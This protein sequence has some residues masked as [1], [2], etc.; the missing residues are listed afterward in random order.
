MLRFLLAPFIAFAHLYC[1][2]PSLA[3]VVDQV[4]ASVVHI[5]TFVQMDDQVGVAFCT[6]EVVEHDRVL[7]A[8]HCAGTT[9]L[10]EGRPAV[11]IALDI[12]DDLA[13]LSTQTLDLPVITMR[14]T[15]V[16]F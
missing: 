7:T 8:A 3:T 14:D 9:M 1:T 4:R 6:G 12:H 10:V 11:V 2:T 16:K 15:P 5:Q 13:I